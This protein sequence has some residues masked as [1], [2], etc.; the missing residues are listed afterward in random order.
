VIVGVLVE[1]G[2]HFGLRVRVVE[3]DGAFVARVGGVVCEF[4][5]VEVVPAVDDMGG[6][7]VSV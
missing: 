7:L 3:P 1:V 6:E 4:E 2:D 5:G